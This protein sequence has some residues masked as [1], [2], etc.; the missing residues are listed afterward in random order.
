MDA[1]AAKRE[2]SYAGQRNS[3]FRSVSAGRG[4]LQLMLGYGMADILALDHEDHHL[5]DVGGVVG[6]ALQ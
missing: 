5:G 1:K 4:L 2:R 3:L 6:D